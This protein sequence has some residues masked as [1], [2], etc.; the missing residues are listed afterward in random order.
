MNAVIPP[1]PFLQ[2][3]GM[4]VI[5]WRDW[6]RVLQVY[7]DAAAKDAMLV[8]KNALLLNVLG[9]EGV[10]IYF[11]AVE[12]LTQAGADGGTNDAEAVDVFEEVLVVLGRC[13]AP[14]EDKVVT[15]LQFKR[16]TQA[17]L[18]NRVMMAA[19]AASVPDRAE[20][21]MADS[22]SEEVG[23]PVRQPGASS[24][25]ASSS[26]RADG[27]FR[28]RSP[29]HWANFPGCPVRRRF[30]QTSGKKGY[31]F[32]MC[33]SDEDTPRVVD[34]VET[35]VSAVT[36]TATVLHVEDA[37]G[38][39]A[40]L[41]VPVLVNDVVLPLMIDTGVVLSLMHLGHYQQ[42]IYFAH[43]PLRPS[44]LVPQNYSEH[45][46]KILGSFKAEVRFQDKSAPVTFYVTERGSSLLG[47]DAIKALKII[48]VGEALSFTEVSPSPLGSGVT[49]RRTCVNLYGT[50][51]FATTPQANPCSLSPPV[52][53]NLCR[54]LEPPAFADLH[55]AATIRLYSALSFS[56]NKRHPE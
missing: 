8:H 47:L 39:L 32:Q 18:P 23:L 14:E 26:T 25:S 42:Y 40:L 17:S 2:C 4:P 5:P 22:E 49:S 15:R 54:V 45:V 10:R 13:F 51:D 52:T 29:Q 20:V 24:P 48:I 27:C 53:V 3:P 21:K 28:C 56:A 33:R 43:I 1:P 34:V 35:R 36:H 41:R 50:A 55:I 46:V 7:I 37:I 19:N 38:A 31:F 44:H 30:C 16:R 12:E 11:A 6:H 9:V